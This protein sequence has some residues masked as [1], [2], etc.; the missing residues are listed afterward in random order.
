MNSYSSD[1][2]AKLQGK[3]SF[4]HL[5]DST[6]QG[7]FHHRNREKAYELLMERIPR[8]DR[9]IDLG[10]STGSWVDTWRRL[11]IQELIGADPNSNVERKASAA[12]DKFYCLDAVKLSLL[13]SEEKFIVANAVTIHITELEDLLAFFNAV[14]LMLEKNG[15]FMVTFVNPDRYLGAR[16]YGLRGETFSLYS[17]EN[18]LAF[19]EESG[20]RIDF[21]VGTFI[22]PW[23]TPNFD[24]L[25]NSDV[26]TRNE[27]LWRPF[28]L[29]SD[30]LRDKVPSE[31]TEI[32]VLCR[33]I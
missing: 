21:T 11:G 23:S 13:L 31:F 7:D 32:L 22:E 14:N 28:S 1:Y 6:S 33:K 26:F 25:A 3:V 2:L 30:L 18:N 8:Q 27:N 24:F 17:I 19:L 9:V 4:T 5:D 15:I 10:C 29:L 20:F 12:F 16:T